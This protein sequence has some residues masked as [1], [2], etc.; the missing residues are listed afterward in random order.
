MA[1]GAKMIEALLESGMSEDQLE[2]A[3][4]T[5]NLDLRH[6]D[7]YILVEPSSRSDRTFADF[8][9]DAGDRGPMIP[10]I[11]QVLGIP[12][13]DHRSHLPVAEEELVE[14]FVNAWSSAPDDQTLIRAARMVA[15]GTRLAASG[16]PELFNEQVA[17]PARERL[18]R[19]ELDRFPPEIGLAAARLFRLI[20]KV[21]TWLAQRYM[22]QGVVAGIVE[23][24]EEFLSTR[25][26]APVPSPA[27][28]PAVLFVDLSGYTDLTEEHG[29]DTAVRASA[30]LQE[31]AEAVAIKEGGRL[32]K[33]LG[34]GAML[35]F[36]N[37]SRAVIAALELVRE[38]TEDLGVSAHAGINA[39]PVIERDLDLFGRT[40]NLASRIAGQAGPGEVIASSELIDLTGDGFHFEPLPQVTL[41]GIHEPITLYRVESA[42]D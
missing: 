20:P 27:P 30:L 2:V 12:Q 22:E 6:V 23:G 37:P 24:F 19:G 10:A 8:I 25:G 38:L 33:L 15:E 40:V 7:N 29:D 41:K 34:D 39:G 13:P 14:E 11:Y 4:R 36:R 28:P 16:W 35:F 21:M 3:A 32:V 31:R 9:S 1:S 18:Y 26:L 5:G 17:T 42:E